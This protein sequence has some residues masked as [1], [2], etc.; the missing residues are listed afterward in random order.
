MWVIVTAPELSKAWSC[1]AARSLARTIYASASVTC[2][3]QPMK[4]AL[5]KF[6]LLTAALAYGWSRQQVSPEQLQVE[7]SVYY[8]GCNEARAAGVAPIYRGQ[9]GYREEMDGDGDGVACEPYRGR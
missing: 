7:Q 8:S 2:D 6:G 5:I 4:G 9:P 3:D 1:R